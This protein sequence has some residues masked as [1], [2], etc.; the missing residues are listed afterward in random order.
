MK[1]QHAV[2]KCYYANEFKAML[3]S[4]GM[5]DCHEQQ[6]KYVP[7]AH[8]TVSSSPIYVFVSP[9]SCFTVIVI[10]RSCIVFVMVGVG[11]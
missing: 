10:L 7:Q 8:S 1:Y 3:T 4:V 11:Y 9:V 5:C 2:L 6:M